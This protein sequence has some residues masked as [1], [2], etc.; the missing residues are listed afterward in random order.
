MSIDHS[1]G[2][3]QSSLG[4]PV[5]EAVKGGR[6]PTLKDVKRSVKVCRSPSVVYDPYA[7]VATLENSDIIHDA[8]GLSTQ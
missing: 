5:T 6:I 7:S 3:R 2:K 1:A 8:H 4:D